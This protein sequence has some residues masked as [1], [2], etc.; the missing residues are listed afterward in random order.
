[1]NPDKIK[2]VIAKLNKNTQPVDCF[3]H[4]GHT[5]K[6]ISIYKGWYRTGYK[7]VIDE[8]T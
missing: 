1:M 3:Y 7:W 8:Q 2:E 5:Y 6:K 4:D